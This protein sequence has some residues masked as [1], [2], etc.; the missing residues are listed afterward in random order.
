M[1]P[2]ESHY[3]AQ[4]Q[5]IQAAAPVDL[6]SGQT[7]QPFDDIRIFRTARRGLWGVGLAH[8]KGA[9]R[10]V[11]LLGYYVFTYLKQLAWLQNSH[12][13]KVLLHFE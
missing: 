12:P 1:I 8:G 10:Q 6:A 5:E 11:D 13:S 2:S 7:D 3:V 9:T 4:V